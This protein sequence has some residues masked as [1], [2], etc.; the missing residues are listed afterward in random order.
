MKSRARIRR[1]PASPGALAIAVLLAAP[2]ATSARGDDMPIRKA[3]LW[4]IIMTMSG[5]RTMTMSQCTDEETDRLMMTFSNPMTQSACSRQ[6]FRRTAT[7]YSGDS[8]CSIAGRSVT[9][10]TDVTGDFNSAYTVQVTSS[11]DGA[12]AGGM[13]MNAHWAGACRADQ[14][15]GDVMM[16]NGVKMNM[17]DLQALKGALPKR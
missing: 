14:K 12:T 2:L 11:G 3:G 9:S 10:H 5:G 8:T 13:T 16:P 15:P 1:L 4:E 17:K 7:G 6:D